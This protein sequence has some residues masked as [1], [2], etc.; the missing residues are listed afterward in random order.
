[1]TDENVEILSSQLGHK[2]QPRAR[3]MLTKSRLMYN[4][5]DKVQQ[6]NRLPSISDQQGHTE[7]V[8]ICTCRADI[9]TTLDNHHD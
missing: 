1:M 6:L 4:R 9:A 3:T 7:A 8:L 2:P 5:G